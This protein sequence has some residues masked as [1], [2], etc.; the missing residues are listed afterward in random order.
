MFNPLN[1]PSLARHR[2]DD[3]LRFGKGPFEIRAFAR[4]DVEDRHFKDHVDI[5]SA[6]AACPHPLRRFNNPLNALFVE[7]QRHAY[8]LSNLRSMSSSSCG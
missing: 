6:D 3:G 8:L 2:R 4:A 5:P 1:T 7:R